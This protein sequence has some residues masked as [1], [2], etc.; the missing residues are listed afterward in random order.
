MFQDALWL[1][2]VAPHYS[3]LQ[4]FSWQSAA[5]HRQDLCLIVLLLS[6]SLVSVIC[7]G[8]FSA[9]F[10]GSVWAV[11]WSSCSVGDVSCSGLCLCSESVP[12][13]LHFTLAASYLT[14]GLTANLTHTC[15]QIVHTPPLQISCFCAH[16]LF[17]SPLIR[18]FSFQTAS[19]ACHYHPDSTLTLSLLCVSVLFVSVFL[20]LITCLPTRISCLWSPSWYL[21]SLNM[22]TYTCLSWIEG[23]T[24][25]QLPNLLTSSAVQHTQQRWIITNPTN[26]K[27]QRLSQ[28]RS[29]H[30]KAENNPLQL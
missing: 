17:F 6:D 23:V 19:A 5:A 14:G 28:T 10:A 27:M 22:H 12:G 20:S 13:V 7:S 3:N 1:H 26:H 29:Q 30:A 4:A 16:R 25:M 15:T 2:T 11:L 8:Y 24:S 9:V 18:S 21:C